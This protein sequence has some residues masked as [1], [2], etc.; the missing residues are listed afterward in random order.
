MKASRLSFRHYFKA[1]MLALA[2][3]VGAMIGLGGAPVLDHAAWAQQAGQVPGNALGNNSDTE[4]W[5]KVRRGDRF[6][7]STPDKKAGILVQSQGDNWRAFR[8][9]PLSVYG[10]WS[11]AGIVIALAVFFLARGRIRVEQGLSGREV[12]RFNGVERFIHWLTAISFVVLGLTGLNMLFGR[13]VLL[14]VL[15]ADAFAGLTLAG[16]YTHDFVAFGFMAGIVLTFVIW[17]RDNIPDRYDLNW[18]ASTGGMFMKGV[19]PPARKFNA[20][21]KLIFWSVILGGAS[22][23][24]SGLSLMFPFDLPLFASTNEVVNII[25]LGLRTDYTPIEEMQLAQNWHAIV[26]LVMIVIIIAHIYIGSLG[27]E[28]AFWAMGTG[29]V[30]ENWAK[31]HHSVWVAELAGTAEAAGQGG[32]D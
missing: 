17:I 18:I 7:I 6:G 15:G 3:I 23:S 9:G 13:Y 29:L 10:G 4:L 26:A 31:E 27:M 21:Q 11:L 28:G 30:D 32:D 8:N 1:G 20:G 25:G 2:L 22:L 24:L 19:H 14:P 5:R 16:K 12:V